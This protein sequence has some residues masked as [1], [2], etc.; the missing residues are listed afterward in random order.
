MWI[1]II[2]EKQTETVHLLTTN[3]SLKQACEKY[4]RGEHLKCSVDKTENPRA[5]G[6]QSNSYLKMPFAGRKVH[7]CVM[8]PE[9]PERLFLFPTL[10]CDQ[11]FH[12][13]KGERTFKIFPKELK[14]IGQKN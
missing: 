10:R 11:G 5:T 14:M 4:V 9:G 13:E 1:C 12:D 2:R 8:L 7:W 3:T 6:S